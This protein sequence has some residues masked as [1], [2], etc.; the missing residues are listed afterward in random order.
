MRDYK[1]NKSGHKSNSQQSIIIT[2]V[3]VVKVKEQKSV[4]KS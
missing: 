3:E 4:E 1:N 2:R